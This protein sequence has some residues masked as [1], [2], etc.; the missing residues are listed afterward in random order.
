MDKQTKTQSND[1]TLVVRKKGNKYLPNTISKYD[2]SSIYK[3]VEFN[4]EVITIKRGKNMN[5]Y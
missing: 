3:N 5:K 1:W 2:P 4:M